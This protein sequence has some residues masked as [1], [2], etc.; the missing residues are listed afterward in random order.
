M[1]DKSWTPYFRRNVDV[2]DENR[3]ELKVSHIARV[4]GQGIQGHPA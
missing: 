3:K 2:I 1:S 4:K